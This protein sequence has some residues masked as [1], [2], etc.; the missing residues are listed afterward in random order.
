MTTCTM[1]HKQMFTNSIDVNV[2]SR[3]DYDQAREIADRKASEAVH[4]PMLMAWYEK[5]TG[6][7]SP[8][9]ECCSE[10]KPGWL[11]Y[12]ESRGGDIVVDINNQEYVFVYRG[13]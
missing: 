5:R 9:V 7:F 8:Q 2:D 12:A 6:R 1:L 3:L 13:N 11:V 4:D 10:E